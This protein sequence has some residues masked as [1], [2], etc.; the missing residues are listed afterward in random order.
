ME[1]EEIK[2]DAEDLIHRLMVE[3]G[4]E[5]YKLHFD[6]KT[7]AGDNYACVILFLRV[8]PEG[9]QKPYNLVMKTAKRSKDINAFLPVEMIYNREL[10]IYTKVFPTYQKFIEDTKSVFSLD[11][12]PKT[13]LTSDISW[14]QT[15]IFENLKSRG[16]R[17]HDRQKSWDL[18]HSLLAME[19]YGEFHALSLA[20]KHQRP[21]EYEELVKQMPNVTAE[22]NKRMDMKFLFQD[23]LDNV[24][25]LL[26]KNGRQD[27]VDKY[28]G[29]VEDVDVFIKHPGL[30]EGD[31]MLIG[32]LDCWNNNF[33]FKYEN[34]DDSKPSSICLLDFQLSS[35]CSPAKDLS[36]NIYST[37]DK[38]CLAHFD[39]IL[40][41]YYASLSDSL[42]R[43]GCKPDE[44]FTY[45]QLQQ[46]WRKYAKFG[47]LTSLL[48]LRICLVDKEDAPDFNEMAK[49]AV[50]NDNFS[51]CFNVVVKNQ[52]EYNRR[53]F[54]A[55]VHFGEN[56]L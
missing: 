28:D 7:E 6:G 51:E 47:L 35:L 54:D 20:L 4:V 55:F 29:L 5:K 9:D 38:A 24:L 37:C 53:V 40:K 27:L 49:N 22:F 19:K 30:D 43:L 48:V 8:E 50:N 12:V 14:K 15:I 11:F 45:E 2:K 42:E 39:E 17:L 13:Y 41:T 23:L 16:F 1:C 18:D 26:Q 10:L 3:E 31:N 34:E 44:I 36:Y 25:K 46:H 32:H 21:D 33:M 56:F 52:D